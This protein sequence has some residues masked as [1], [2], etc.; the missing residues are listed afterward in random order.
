MQYFSV[1]VVRELDTKL[2]TASPAVIPAQTVT[3]VAL[4]R[5]PAAA[6]A[7]AVTV[8]VSGYS[9]TG[10]AVVYACG[11]QMP[12]TSDINF[13]ASVPSVSNAV[14]TSVNAQE[15]CVFASTAVELV[16]D[17]TGYWAPTAGTQYSASVTRLF[18]SRTQGQKGPEQV[19]Y[20]GLTL[21]A[22]TSAGATVNV[23][24]VGAVASGTV[25]RS[26]CATGEPIQM[27]TD[28][29]KGLVRPTAMSFKVDPADPRLCFI[30]TTPV[31][32]I[33]DLV[34]TWKTNR[35]EMLT[36]YTAPSRVLDTRSTGFV[37]PGAVV[38]LLPQG[39][40]VLLGNVTTTGAQAQG[41]VAVFPCNAG[42]QGT[43]TVNFIPGTPAANSVLVDSRLGGVCA[44]S[45]TPVHLI[46]DVKGAI[47]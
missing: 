15:M 4:P 8:T 21:D 25:Y 44:L 1:P 35:P 7:A 39:T 17:L 14:V 46:L 11:S 10:Y 38:Q 13:S 20:I 45:S 33:F 29:Y 9:T 6:L 22:A 27:V 41:W 31:E 3:K 18:D 32:L 24:A 42:A 47:K 2:P 30:S 40:S 28:V 36:M 37:A 5:L 34:G 16:V 19:F 23:T 26:V 12:Q 43:S